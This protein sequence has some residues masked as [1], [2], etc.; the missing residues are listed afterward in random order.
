M[1]V[2]DQ[3]QNQNQSIAVGVERRFR[4]RYNS[5][6]ESR[7]AVLLPPADL[8]PPRPAGGYPSYHPKWDADLQACGYLD[9]FLR[10]LAIKY[11]AI[12]PIADAADAAVAAVGATANTV[13][14]AAKDAAAAPTAAFDA[15]V[16]AAAAAGGA[17]PVAV[18][19]AAKDAAAAAVAAPNWRADYATVARQ[20]GANLPPQEMARVDLGDEVMAILE[21]ALEREARFAE[22]IDQDDGDGSINYWLGMLKI[23]PARHPNTFLMVHLGRRI[24]EH[25][26][27]CL[28]YDFKSPRP[29][30]LCPAITPMIDPPATPSYPAGHAVQSYLISLLLAY[31]FSNPAGQTNLPQHTQRQAN[32]TVAQFLADLPTGPL[33]RLADRVAWNR[34]IAGIHY[35]T[36]IRAGQAVAL[37]TFVDIQKVASIWGAG[38]LRDEVRN[39]FPQYRR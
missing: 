30:Q 10:Y 24:G 21:L 1:A 13:A 17:T 34:V 6:V 28:K 25:V 29:P 5:D 37:Q 22:I 18:A 7:A 12:K 32:S 16:D 3:N 27:M 26:A 11:L 38:G 33:F 15:A 23:D 9:D 8:V 4:V 36:D 2:L 31:S 19:N 20:G 39:E 14:T 35:P